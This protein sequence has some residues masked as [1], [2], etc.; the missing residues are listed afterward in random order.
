MK[1]LTDRQLAVLKLLNQKDAMAHYMPYMGRFNENQ[2][3][4]LSV[5]HRR[6]TREIRALKDREL[7]EVSSRDEFGNGTIA[8]INLKG[9]AALKAEP[10]T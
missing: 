10:P 3:W 8:V 4:Y 7:V 6:V 9:I 5:D 1:K 2:Y